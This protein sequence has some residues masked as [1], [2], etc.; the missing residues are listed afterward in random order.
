MP[1]PEAPDLNEA[2]LL[3]VESGGCKASFAGTCMTTTGGS[4]QFRHLRPLTDQ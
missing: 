4:T 2:S 3:S 1:M